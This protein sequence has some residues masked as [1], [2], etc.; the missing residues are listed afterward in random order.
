MYNINEVIS[1]Y[2]TPTPIIR[3]TKHALL[4]QDDKTMFYFTPKNQYLSKVSKKSGYARFS[5]AIL[6]DLWGFLKVKWLFSMS[7][8]D[9]NL[10]LDRSYQCDT[11]SK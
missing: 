11:V 6:F 3:I 4:L 7:N 10:L 8:W 1:K 5:V 9:E 2:V